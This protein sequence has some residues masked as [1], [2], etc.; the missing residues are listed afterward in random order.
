VTATIPVGDT[1]N[2]VAAGTVYVTNEGSDTVSGVSGGGAPDGPIASGYRASTC[3]QA[4]ASPP[5]NGTPAVLS[6]CDHSAGQ[7]WA[8]APDGTIRSAT[9]RCLDVYRQQKA[10][11]TPVDLYARTGRPNQQRN[12][13]PPGPTARAAPP[14]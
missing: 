5:A 7:D 3:V 11:K 6:G 10:S 4:G 8:I 1:P 14:R 13:P 9:G 12:L 2:G